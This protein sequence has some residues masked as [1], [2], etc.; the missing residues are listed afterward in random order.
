MT[1][2]PLPADPP[3]PLTTRA[4]TRLNDFLASLPP[5]AE[6]TQALVD[7]N[8]LLTETN[9]AL[10]AARVPDAGLRARIQRLVD[11]GPQWS[12]HPDIRDRVP[13]D[14][15]WGKATVAVADLRAALA[16]SPAESSNAE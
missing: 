12:P 15:E 10:D 16:S 1:D 2:H 7:V 8:I 9:A 13:D 5:S 14:S 4:G 3:S 6:R 11:E